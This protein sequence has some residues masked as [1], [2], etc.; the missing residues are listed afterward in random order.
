MKQAILRAVLTVA[1]CVAGC[2]DRSGEPESAQQGSPPQGTQDAR[3]AE[4]ATNEVMITGRLVSTDG[5]PLPGESV[6]GLF[7]KTQSIRVGENGV[8]LNPTARTDEQGSFTLKLDRTVLEDEQEEVVIAVNR[9]PPGDFV[10]RS[11]PLTNAEGVPIG[12]VFKPG[13]RKV[14][15]GTITVK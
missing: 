11:T 10:S 9:V 12:L 5:S 13:V 4:P 3:Q 14:D 1:V 7:G 6:W 2:P 8:L 15:L